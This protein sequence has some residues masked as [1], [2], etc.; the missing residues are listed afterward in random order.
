MNKSDS[1]NELATALAKAQGQIQGAVR[2]SQNPFFKSSYA[3]LASV[4]E[5]CRKPLT[6]NG[7]SVV[8]LPRAV[9]EL[10][11]VETL[12][13]HVSGQFVSE[14]LA[15]RPVKADP[16][17]V[18]SVI[19]YLRR[20]A[21][22]AIVGV[23][24]VDDDAEGAMERPR[25]P[26]YLIPKKPPAPETLQQQADREAR[27]SGLSEIYSSAK[28]RGI[29]DDEWRAK[30]AALGITKDKR[31]HSKERLVQLGQWVI[32]WIPSHPVATS[33]P[34]LEWLREVIRAASPALGLV[35][36]Q[37]ILDFGSHFAGIPDDLPD[38]ALLTPEQISAIAE[39][40]DKRGGDTK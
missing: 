35:S 7:L 38:V 19:S 27:P 24:Q 23:Y 18:G 39:E 32:D 25:P 15:A 29:P 13:L 4:W 8:Q 14:V 12:L 30:M 37:A 5:A 17:G 6:E 1:L 26:E 34:T 10:I 9:G 11:E 3:D 16:Q 33:R 2:D 36:D 20:Y 40:I 28:N 21:L 22:A 31:S